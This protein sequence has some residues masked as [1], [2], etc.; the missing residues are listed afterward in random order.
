MLC[1]VKQECA[2]K[3]FDWVVEFSPGCHCLSWYS[4][5][6]AL[7]LRKAS[8]ISTRSKRDLPVGR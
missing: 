1:V 4:N 6:D 7:W 2:A 3:F 8:A 5:S